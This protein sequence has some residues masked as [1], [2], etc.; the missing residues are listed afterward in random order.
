LVIAAAKTSH[1]YRISFPM[2]SADQHALT[3]A[4]RIAN[5]SGS[6]WTPRFYPRPIHTQAD[7]QGRLE[8]DVKRR[9]ERGLLKG[10]GEPTWLFRQCQGQR[11][12]GEFAWTTRQLWRARRF[13]TQ[14]ISQ[15]SFISL[16]WGNCVPPVYTPKWHH[17]KATPSTPL[18][19][20]RTLFRT[21]RNPTALSKRFRLRVQLSMHIQ[22]FCK[23]CCM[24]LLMGK[25]VF[26]N[27]FQLDPVTCCWVWLILDR[28]GS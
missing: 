5:G 2:K 22:G 26:I 20:T 21:R 13:P 19:T 10:F 18:H 8:E 14:G 24:L 11:H 4:A 17:V 15:W 6:Q 27:C 7:R 28:Y 16:P 23:R 1:R 25:R 3:E 12:K 9:E